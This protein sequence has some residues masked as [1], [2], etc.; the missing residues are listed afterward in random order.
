MSTSRDGH[1]SGLRSHRTRIR[2]GIVLAAIAAM[3]VAC[4]SSGQGEA[5]EGNV[6]TGATLRI[7]HVG[8]V[9]SLDPTQ[10]RLGGEQGAT[11]LLY[12]R[13]TQL[14]ND[15]QVRPML[16]TSW[17]FAPDGSYLEMKLRE[18]VNFHDGT[19]VDAKAVKASLERGKTQPGS[20]V[21]ESLSDIA[22]VKVVD[23]T[24][25]RLMLE[26]G[27]GAGLPA[28]LASNAGEIISPKAI[29]DKR[30]LSLD[31][32]DAG[33]GA[34]LVTE[35]KPN[36]SVAL[37]RAPGKYWDPRA[38]KVKRIEIRYMPQASVGLNA[39]RSGQL[40][41]VVTT[42]TD[43]ESVQKLAESGRVRK[44]E[45]SLLT[46]S[47]AL[48]MNPSYPTFRDARVRNAISQAI[49]RAAICRDLLSGNC[50]PR[51]QPY[52]KGHW[53]HDAA[54]DDLLQYTP[55]KAKQ[56]LAD[57]GATKV[58]F[59]LVF[60][61]GSS[62]ESVAQAMQSQLAKSGITVDLKPLPS[63]EAFS[64]YR[65]GRYPAYLTTITAAVDPA[66]LMDTQFLGGYNAAEAVRE[67][68]T[69]VALRADKPGLPQDQRARLYGQIWN[70]IADSS[71]MIPV[72]TNKLAWA[73]SP[74]VRGVDN[75][76]WAWA[77]G[78]DARYLSKTG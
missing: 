60:T 10:Q 61:A 25:V 39:L 31:P 71:S 27:R 62:Y 18:G 8:P 37:E 74:K 64:G 32:R 69:P 1:S 12:D 3:T 24:T 48:F 65:E 5:P 15:Y 70:R 19:P 26:P 51:V 47:H 35:F 11:F 4:S 7:G 40:D 77:G 45:Y 67:A 6:D 34:Y 57:A 33:S 22:S 16:A 50:T 54:L 66:Q 58:R 29:A 78:F 2:S 21:A 75:L 63:T 68:V 72:I 17:E 41:M 9:P 55:D 42:A 36:E 38:A 43:V 20:T 30:D 49:D 52:P 44:S 76:P 14:T 28:I 23:A 73:Y 59:P 56:T 13:L 53:A 46:P